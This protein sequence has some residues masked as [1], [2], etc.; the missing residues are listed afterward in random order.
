[1]YVCNAII[2]LQIC[3]L[4][5]GKRLP[6]HLLWKL[7]TTFKYMGGWREYTTH[8][9]IHTVYICYGFVLITQL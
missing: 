9:H 5:F 4:G 3:A 1:M 7:H 8:T 6:M 2:S